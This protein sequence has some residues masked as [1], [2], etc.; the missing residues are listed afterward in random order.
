MISMSIATLG[1]I[2]HQSDTDSR[3]LDLHPYST[4]S[5]EIKGNFI[6]RMLL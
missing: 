6:S 1:E 3:G 4:P 2:L 5:T